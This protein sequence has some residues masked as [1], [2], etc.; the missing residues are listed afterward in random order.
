MNFFKRTSFKIPGNVPW[1]TEATVN[2]IRRRGKDLAK[3]ACSQGWHMQLIDFVSHRHAMPFGDDI[4][5]IIAKRNGIHAMLTEPP[6]QVL[7]D[8][9]RLKAALLSPLEAKAE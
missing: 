4:E 7:D 1:S 3:S 9:E 6:K 2:F 5:A 8:R